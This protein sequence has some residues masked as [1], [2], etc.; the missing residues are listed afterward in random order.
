MLTT[1]L[2]SQRYFYEQNME[3]Q[4]KE[5]RKEIEKLQLKLAD[6]SD[7]KQDAE[8]KF[9]ETSKER[10]TLEKKVYINQLVFSISTQNVRQQTCLLTLLYC[11]VIRFI[12]SHVFSTIKSAKSLQS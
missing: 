7:K 1:Q 12:V 9:S 5:F 11:I 3:C 10:V 8:F 4:S 6:L 2:D